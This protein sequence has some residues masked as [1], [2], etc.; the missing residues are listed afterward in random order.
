[1]ESSIKPNIKDIKDYIGRD[2][3]DLLRASI[4]FK[5]IKKR[6]EGKK[7]EEE[8]EVMID[9]DVYQTKS[10]SPMGTFRN[11]RSKGL[12]VFTPQNSDIIEFITLYNEDIE[13]YRMCPL[14]LPYKLEWKH[15]NQDVVRRLGDSKNKGGGS[16]PVWINFEHMGISFQ[17]LNN[18]WADSANPI[19]H[20]TIFNPSKQQT[21]CSLCLRPVAKAKDGTVLAQCLCG[22]SFCSSACLDD[23]KQYHLCTFG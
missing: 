23:F 11:F 2:I 18:D 1:M 15:K 19:T 10:G 4:F 14:K 17:F 7:E 8:E 22:L 5:I 13:S 3:Q 6:K 12:S 20:I 16:I 9:Q 21:D